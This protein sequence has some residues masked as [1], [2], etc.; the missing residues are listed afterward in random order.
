MSIRSEFEPGLTFADENLLNGVEYFYSITAFNI[1]GESEPS[2]TISGIPIP[3]IT[4]PGIPENVSLTVDGRSVILTWSEPKD[5]GRSPI[6][7]YVI[8][9]GNNDDD[10]EI[11]AN[12]SSVNNFTDTDLK[13][14]RTYYYQIVAKNEMYHGNATEILVGRIAKEPDDS[15][16]YFISI[17][18]VSLLL[19][20]IL[21]IRHRKM[22][23]GPHTT[24]NE[25]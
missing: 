17:S 24:A 11:L 19:I 25:D 6:I 23:Q 8:L 3:I 22:H 20:S 4:P 5:D 9:R 15:P 2:T 1:I 21:S 13:R 10:L 7:G 14:G 12:V 18:V 16:G